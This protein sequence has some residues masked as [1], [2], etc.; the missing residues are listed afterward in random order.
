MIEFKFRKESE[1][2]VETNVDVMECKKTEWLKKNAGDDD[3]FDRY[4]VIDSSQGQVTVLICLLAEPRF[5]VYRY[6]YDRKRY[7]RRKKLYNHDG[8]ILIV[9][10]NHLPGIV[11]RSFS[12]IFVCQNRPVPLIIN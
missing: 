12:K 11:Q 7:M 9:Q 4:Q 6:D 3:L 10:S 8:P 1:I 2:T 5:G